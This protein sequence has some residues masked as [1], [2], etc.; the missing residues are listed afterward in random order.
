MVCLS[1]L[2]G[3]AFVFKADECEFSGLT[4]FVPCNMTVRDIIEI[5]FEMVFDFLFSEV[6]GYIFDDNS[7]H[8]CVK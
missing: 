1:N 7:A 8:K 4:F 3:Y 6:L 2:L 5:V